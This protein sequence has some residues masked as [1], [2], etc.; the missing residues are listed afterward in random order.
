MNKAK[1]R[2]TFGPIGGDYTYILDTVAMDQVLNLFQEKPE[3]AIGAAVVL[4]LVFFVLSSGGSS[5]EKT[6]A[7]PTASKATT[8]KKKESKSKSA[9][10]AA[11]A[12]P[13]QKATEIV[14]GK[15]AS[16][17]KKKKKKSK[18]GKKKETPTPVT[19][20]SPT[21]TT[22]ATTAEED[23]DDDD[24]DLLA[25]RLLS[26]KALAKTGAAAAV[27]AAEANSSNKNAGG[28]KK[29]KKKNKK[30]TS[31]DSNAAPQEPVVADDWET[32]GKGAVTAA[33]TADGTPQPIKVHIEQ[34]DIPVLIGPKGSTIQNM[35]TI[36]GAKLDVTNNPSGTSATLTI[37]AETV[38]SQSLALAQV[39]SLLTAAQEERKRAKA[40]SITLASTDIKGSEGVKAIIGRGGSTIKG[41]QASTGTNV[42]A[43]VED[44]Q[45]VITGSSME[46]VEEAAKLCRHAVF[47]ECQEVLELG[48]RA[49]VLVVYGKD[50]QKIRQ[51]QDQSGAKLDIEKGGTKLTI[52]GPTENVVNA[53]K[54]VQQWVEYNK[55]ISF[56][57][58]VDKVGA[59]Y[60]KAGANI[61][62]IQEK[63]GAFVEIDDQTGSSKEFIQCK[64]LGEPASV[65]A[66]KAMFQKSLDGE[67]I[68]LR[69]GEVQIA[70]ELGAGTPAVIGKGGSKIAQL[71]KAH[72]VKIFVNSGSQGC[73]IVGSEAAVSNAKKAIS[74]I[75][76][77]VIA[78]LE[79][80]QEADR[81]ATQS[82]TP[83]HPLPQNGTWVRAEEE[84]G[85]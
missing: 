15:T 69:D 61:R 76:Q 82:N 66:A 26:S 37:T 73:S 11:P 24:D 20:E 48:T 77:P 63:T 41:I 83:W 65:A 30:A 55:G 8:K 44:A 29:K 53:K 85:W 59:V 12:V 2:L 45:V 40:F 3:Y 68:E 80:K 36:S 18:A 19:A 28:K 47:G 16:K 81:L 1:S 23:S 22:T 4:A 9:P 74:A 75:I 31:T 43:N 79:M 78:E 34:D 21:T 49:M 6:K 39:Q 67:A 27:A 33:V 51:M 46:A 70:M 7:V 52:S 72:S 56:D 13:A 32:V 71:E 25:A 54:M 17:S 62:R 50:Y 35:Q 14:G 84:T 58:D 5:S 57:I 42:D 10:A 60:G 38:D 64:I